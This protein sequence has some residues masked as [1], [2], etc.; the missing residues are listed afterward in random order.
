M[1]EVTLSC[2]RFADWG[3]GQGDDAHYGGFMGRFRRPHL[4][5]LVELIVSK[6]D[7][8]EQHAVKHL[9]V[10][11]HVDRFFHTALTSCWRGTAVVDP[12]RSSALFRPAVGT[13][14]VAC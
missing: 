7:V 9:V 10:E 4:L 1:D 11:R 5:L 6:V 14:K 13:T 2:G 8:C 12:G 3:Q